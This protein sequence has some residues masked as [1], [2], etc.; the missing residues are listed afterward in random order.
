MSRRAS[1]RVLPSYYGLPRV[2][3]LLRYRDV[4]RRY[5]RTMEKVARF[6]RVVSLAFCTLFSTAG[7]VDFF[8]LSEVRA[9]QRGVGKT[10]FQGTQPEEFQVEILGVLRNTG[11][12]Q[13]II[14]ARLSGGPL[15]HTGV[16]QGMSGSP[17]YIDGR[18]A[19]AVAMGFELAKEPIAGIR[20]IEE[21]LAETPEAARGAARA[22]VHAGDVRLR[23]IAT[24]VSFAGFSAA[25]LEQFAPQLRALGL[26]PRQGVS[27][28]GVPPDRMGDP[29]RLEPGSMITVQ[30]LTGDMTV[31][32]DGTVTLIDGEKIYAFGHSLV[33]AGPTAMPFAQA[34]VLTLLPSLAS[35]FKISQARE[36]MGAITSDGAAAISGLTGRRVPLTPL[37]IKVGERRYQMGVIQDP[38]LTP[39]VTQMA[40]SS[41]LVAAARTVGPVTFTVRGQLRFDAGVVE[42]NDVYSGEVAAGA[43]A[44]LGVASPL[45]YAMS[46]GFEA[47]KLAGVSLDIA[48]LNEARRMEIAGVTGPRWARPG[49]EIELAVL[50][51]GANG[52]EGTRRVR[53]TIPVGSPAQTFNFTVSEASQPNAVDMQAAAA[54]SFRSPRQVLDLLNG[55]RSNT[56]AYLRVVRAGSAFQAGGRELPDPP[57]SIALILNRANPAAAAAGALRGST[58]A[59]VEIPVGGSMVTGSKTIQIEVR[60]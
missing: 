32:A 44:S 38:V 7:A 37:E 43:L 59:E 22:E 54:G 49:E 5:S 21:M 46:K 39:L 53:Y 17:V 19:G 34:E 36:W 12:R 13:S 41:A 33:G 35:S 48:V 14:L 6:R 55:L 29:R 15:A 10:V 50:L 56:N 2:G 9:G 11:P 3:D 8:P 1:F 30:L 18:L 23:E 40:V 4:R 28:G 16:M 60:P 42:L 31:S 26:D 52:A 25:T 51:H 45:S 20:P 57:P 58:V 27:G 24:P 47:L